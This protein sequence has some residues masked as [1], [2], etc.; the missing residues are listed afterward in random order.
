MASEFEWAGTAA[1]RFRAVLAGGAL[2]EAA[3]AVVAAGGHVADRID[4]SRL[5]DLPAADLLVVELESVDE[6]ALADVLALVERAADGMP[7][8]ATV[9]LEQLD[10]SGV[11]LLNS[12]AQLLCRP[13]LADR[14]AA[15]V[16]ATRASATGSVREPGREPELAAEVGRIAEVLARLIRRDPIPGAAE[17][18]QTFGAEPPSELTADFQVDAG[19]VRN[20]IRARRMRDAFF[21]EGLFAD[22]AWDMLLDLFAAGLEGAQVSVS[23]L[24]IAAAVPPTTALRWIGLLS[25]RHLIERVPDPADRRRAFLALSPAAEA[26]MRGYLAATRRT[27]IAAA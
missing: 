17:R 26:A 1:P 24:C 16:V 15:M 3:D 8:V 5:D 22:P 11:L 18:R 2:G 21:G 25:D 12:H 14:V 9:S 23:S 10:L 27:G 19:V 13:A 20:T 4:L 6:A 7:V